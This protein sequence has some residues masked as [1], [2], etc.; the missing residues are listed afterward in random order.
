[1]ANIAK[2]WHYDP[3]DKNAKDNCPNC[4]HWGGRKCKDEPLLIKH[5]EE[6]K[7]FKNFDRTMR[8]NK[9]VYLD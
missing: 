7:T 4:S 1:M 5:Y 8:S 2:R 3:I 9:G 6:S